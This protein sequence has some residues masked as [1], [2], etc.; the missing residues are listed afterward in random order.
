M[1]YLNLIIRCV[2]KF[3]FKSE[4]EIFFFGGGNLGLELKIFFKRLQ[5]IGK[6][7]EILVCDCL[8]VLSCEV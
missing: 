1:I 5:C 2:D 7:N 3:C 4:V 8:V 6:N